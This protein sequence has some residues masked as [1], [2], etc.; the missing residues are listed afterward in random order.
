MESRMIDV[1]K[2]VGINFSYGGNISQT[3]DS[4][5][6]LA[7]AYE[8][9]GE[10]LQRKVLEELFKGY[11]EQVRRGGFPSAFPSSRFADLIA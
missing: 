8:S 7:K 1:G 4:H 9:G 3:V 6:L 11:F 10:P 2:N 5:R